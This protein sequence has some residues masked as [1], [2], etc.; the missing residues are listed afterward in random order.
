[1]RPTI[2]AFSAMAENA[3]TVETWSY[4]TINTNPTAPM[5]TLCIAITG[6]IT[7]KPKSK[8]IY[9]I[10]PKTAFGI[11]PERSLTM[12]STTKRESEK[13]S[14]DLSTDSFGKRRCT[15]C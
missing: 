9:I 1:M 3:R 2:E 7:L 12:M 15:S 4:A 10:A 6:R 14:V 8:I 5:N 13:P 11:S